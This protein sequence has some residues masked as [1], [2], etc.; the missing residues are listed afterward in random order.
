[1]YADLKQSPAYYT[2]SS[3]FSGNQRGTQQKET[4]EDTLGPLIKVWRKG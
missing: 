2:K 3:V 4:C 1:M